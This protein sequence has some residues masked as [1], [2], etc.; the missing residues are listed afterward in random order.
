MH[1]YY[2]F[3]ESS[4]LSETNDIV[5]LTLAITSVQSMTSNYL[6]RKSNV[7]ATEG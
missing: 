2:T 6:C 7:T 4:A 5:T 3:L 1:V